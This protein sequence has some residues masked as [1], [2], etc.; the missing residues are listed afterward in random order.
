[1]SHNEETSNLWQIGLC[2]QSE[3]EFLFRQ[4]QSCDLRCRQTGSTVL[5]LKSQ[6]QEHINS[7]T[8]ANL[9][10]LDALYEPHNSNDEEDDI[11]S[12]ELKRKIAR[13]KPDDQFVPV[14]IGK[15]LEK[16]ITIRGGKGGAHQMPQKLR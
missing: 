9:A 13:P 10:D 14:Q 1:M 7:N 8:E 5:L 12:R 16:V 2:K 11:L 6:P 4:R 15:D 3:D